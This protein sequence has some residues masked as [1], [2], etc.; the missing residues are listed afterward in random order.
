MIAGIA[1]SKQ[2]LLEWVHQ[3]GLAARAGIWSPGI[4]HK[5]R[6]FLTRRL[7][8]LDLLV[9]MLDGLHIAHHTV[10]VALGILS[11]GRKVVLALWQ[12]STENAVLC[13]S[14]LQDLLGRAVLFFLV[15]EVAIP[16]AIAGRSGY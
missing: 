11:D 10:V 9:L 2:A 4:T 13:T 12:G 7:D 15:H 6:T 16:N 8:D 14:L 5:M 3:V 1:R